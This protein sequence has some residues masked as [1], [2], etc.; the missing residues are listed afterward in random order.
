MEQHSEIPLLKRTV[1]GEPLAN[2]EPTAATVHDG[3]SQ[4]KDATLETSINIDAGKPRRLFYRISESPPF[5]LV[6]I[7]ALQQCLMS[8]AGALSTSLL[9][10][11]L[12]CAKDAELIKS[13]V[14]SSTMFMSGLATF[15]MVTVGVRLPIYQGPTNIYIIPLLALTEMQEWRCP[16]Q[17]DLAE[18]YNSTSS[19]NVTVNMRGRYPV[20]L[21]IIHGKLG[22]IMGSL[23][24]VGFIHLMIGATGLVGVLLRFIGPVTIV[25][26]LTLIGLYIY[27]TVVT[28]S[29][30]QW[31][32]SLFT[33]GLALV[34]S[35]YLS[36][37]KT[38]LIAWQRK[39]GF[40]IKWFPLHQV[41]AILLALLLGWALSVILT[42][43]GVLS[44]DPLSKDYYARTDSRNYVIR[45][46]PWFF[47]PYPGQFGT[48]GF[49]IPAFVTFLLATCFS[50]LDSIGDYSACARMCFVP[51]PPKHAVNRGVA[52]EGAMSFLAGAV[53]V[54][55][56]T[57]SYGNNIGAIG[58]TRVASR[59]VFAATGVLFMLMGILGKIG[60]FFVTIPYS[61]IG[62]GMI[63]GVGIFVGIVLSNLQ[64]VDLNSPRNLAIIGISLLLGLMLPHWIETTP[65]GI[66]TGSED[67]DRI[68]KVLL[69][70]PSCAGGVLACFL[71]NTVP[72]TLKE[73]GF[74]IWQHEYAEGD[75]SAA[76]E[77]FE[78]GA[79]VY[80]L[81]CVPEWLMKSKISKYIPFIPSYYKEASHTE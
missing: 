25:P 24:V 6:S 51:P 54:G 81:P 1:D 3:L 27:K 67:A 73:R 55:H 21:E 33:A 58:I 68:I 19:M 78:E 8:I 14:L 69:S 31:G 63:I 50:I 23:M 80:Q 75:T 47:F 53:G 18:Y 72:G 38:P 70:N 37:V 12:V 77:S 34:L 20:P 16:S 66:Q 76:S 48:P 15:L 9:V 40:Y 60:A 36:N 35:I 71:D 2:N 44:D 65:D 11:E 43:Y 30:T 61:V 57:S 49:S 45:Q 17:G 39:R 32:V 64:Y 10:S 29:E 42:E 7:F 41:F 22:T 26:S 28:F 5:Y 52:V 79:E 59:R 4:G 74:D 13:Q 56:A 46:S 62:G